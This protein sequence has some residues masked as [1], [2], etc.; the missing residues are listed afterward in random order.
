MKAIILAAGVGRRL[1][2]YFDRPKCLLEINGKTLIARYLSELSKLEIKSIV[3]VAG[4]KKDQII[5]EV[6]N[7]KVHSIVS[8]VYNPEYAEGSILSLYAAK[9]EINDDIILM[10]GDVYFESDVSSKLLHSKYENCILLD[11]TAKYDEEAMMV[12]ISDDR[13]VT[14]ARGLK[15]RYNSVGEWVGFIRLRKETARTLLDIASEKI[16]QNLLTIG[17]EDCFPDL[18]KKTV[19]NCE[20]VDGL[21]WIEIDFKKDVSRARRML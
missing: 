12:E 19:I 8:F 6:K 10:D 14:M 3:I 1:K 11:R 18:F 15:G 17:Y 4:Y 7:L 13:A 16:T 2:D 5:R 20:Y 9:N 21:K